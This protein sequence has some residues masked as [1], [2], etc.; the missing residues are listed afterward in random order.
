[1]EETPPNTSMAYHYKALDFLHKSTSDIDN[2]I[3]VN[4]V[5]FCPYQIVESNKYPFLQ[6][7]LTNDYDE[8][9]SFIH[10]EVNGALLTDNH[11][12]Q[13]TNYL[14]LKMAYFD[15]TPENVQYKG[16]TLINND[17]YIFYDLTKEPL[18]VDNIHNSNL[19]LAIVDELVNQRAV[20]GVPISELVSDFFTTN[21][22]F[23][24]LYND[25]NEKYEVPMSTYV[26]MPEN[27][28]VFT[29][30][31]GV[32]SKDSQYIVGPYY[33]FTSYE[34]SIK[35]LHHDVGA[36]DKIGIVRF[37]VFL[38]KTKVV[39][40]LP[41]D[42]IDESSIKQERLMDQTHD[43]NYERLTMRISDHDGKWGNAYDSIIIPNIRLDNGALMKDTPIICIKTYEQQWPL[44][45]CFV[46]RYTNKK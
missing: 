9:L 21:P 25:K 35:Q 10:L 14:L 46:R 24:F 20:Y 13:Y 23:H 1:M 44:S 18:M 43:L 28:T 45:Y 11:I 33:Y 30:M 16:F 12:A 6:F 22:K 29:H 42:E 34:N 27:K 3:Q 39:Q 40:N 8:K 17:L 38:E 32:S 5:F 15:I 36:Q 37:A 4:N 2:N 26:A 41:Y 7:L 19:W 31:F